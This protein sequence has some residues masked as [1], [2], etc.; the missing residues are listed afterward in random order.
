[1]RS[2]ACEDRTTPKLPKENH[3]GFKGADSAIHHSLKTICSGVT[4]CCLDGIVL[5]A[6][7]EI[8]I[9]H[10][11]HAVTASGREQ[12]VCKWHYQGASHARSLPGSEK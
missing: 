4:G 12:W 6:Y 1:M 7:V 2:S 3:L 5:D 10:N 8:K 11:K 9:S